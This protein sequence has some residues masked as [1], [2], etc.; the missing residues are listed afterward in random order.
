MANYRVIVAGSRTFSDYD[1]MKTIINKVMQ[2]VLWDEED[3]VTFVSGHA[4]GAD[5]LG[6]RYAEEY[7]FHCDIFP[8]KWDQYGK[9]AG[10]IR[11]GEMADFATEDGY[12]GVLIAFYGG[13]RSGGTKNMIDHAHRHEM[14]TYVVDYRDGQV[15]DECW[16]LSK[17]Q[18]DEYNTYKVSE[19][20]KI[21][22]LN[23]ESPTG[24]CLMSLIH[25]SSSCEDC[26]GVFCYDKSQTCKQRCQ[27]K[28]SGTGYKMYCEPMITGADCKKTMQVVGDLRHGRTKSDDIRPAIEEFLENNEYPRTAIGG[29]LENIL[30]GLLV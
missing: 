12:K 10:F 20:Y 21:S 19:R 30:L 13:N 3:T 25:G 5:K 1:T 7:G 23:S 15:H 26:E 24:L 17:K 28:E 29:E 22:M 16:S 11:N 9:N 2:Y 6:E 14:Y 27:I 4:D 18:D 8:A